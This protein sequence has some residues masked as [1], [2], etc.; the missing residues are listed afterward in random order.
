MSS[1]PRRKVGPSI[2]SGGREA[3]RGRVV[4]DGD[5]DFLNRSKNWNK[6]LGNFEISNLYGNLYIGNI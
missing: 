5:L 4:G 2:T 3:T 6:S 1:M